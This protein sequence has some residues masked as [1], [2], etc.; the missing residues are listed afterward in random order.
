MD[1]LGVARHSIDLHASSHF[2]FSA[3]TMSAQLLTA[4]QVAARLSISRRALY[5]LLARGDFIKPVRLGAR[6]VRYRLDDLDAWVDSRTDVECRSNP[7]G[8]MRE[9]SHPIIRRHLPNV[10]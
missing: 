4:E 6:T 3:R 1:G 9:L 2:G 10:V 7:D 5:A 8:A